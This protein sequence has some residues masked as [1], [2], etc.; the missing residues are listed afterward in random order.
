MYCHESFECTD[1]TL[2]QLMDNNR[3]RNGNAHCEGSHGWRIESASGSD[4]YALSEFLR[5]GAALCMNLWKPL[6]EMGNG[7][8]KRPHSA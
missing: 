5:P 7:S 3:K 4:E 1:F 8:L 6:A 2:S